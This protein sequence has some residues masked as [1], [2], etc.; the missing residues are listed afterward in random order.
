MKALASKLP[1][2][3]KS[4][5]SVA[6]PK[7]ALFVGSF[8]RV[9][10][11]L[12]SG[13][14]WDDLEFVVLEGPKGGLVSPSRD[15][16]FNPKR[17][18][19]MLLVG[20]EPGTYTL[21]VRH[22][23]SSA[24]LW[25]GKFEVD[26]LW[27]DL[28]TGP[29]LWFTGTPSNYSTG[30]A[31]GGGTAGPQNVNVLPATGTRRIAVLLA[32][33]TDQRYTT[34]APT[35][36]QFR[37]RW[38]DELIDGVVDGGVTRSVR[39][40]YRE[41]SY[42]N[43]DISAQVFG[44]VQLPGAW[45]DYFAMDSGGNWA[46]AAA[47]WQA[48]V[49]AG[50][51]LIDYTQFDTLVCVSQ[52][53]DGPPQ[54]RA[55]PYANGGTF[56]TAEGNRS[57]GVISMPNEW[58]VVG[59]REIFDTFSHELGHN[60]GLGD[61]YTPAVAGR[62]LG[63]WEMMD[64]DDP[65]PHFTL[66]H[67]MMLGWVQSGWVQSFDFSAL[68]GT[69]DQTVTLHPI[70]LGNPASGRRSGIEIRI[71]DGW[72]YYL[73]YRRGQAAHIG[74]RALPED[75]IVLGTDVVSAPYTP[76]FSR[77]GLL[78]LPP[79]TDSEGAALSN[80]ENYR[81]TDFSDPTYP[82]DFRVDVSGIDA[83]KADVR[84]RYGVLSKP[85][86]SIRPW[87]AAPDRQWQSPDIE[88]R[89][90]RNQA[91]A[92]WFNVPWVGNANTIVARV[93]NNGN[94]A[95]PQVRVNFYVKNYNVG[96]APESFLGTDARDIPAGAAVEFSTGWVP[97]SNGHYCVIVRIPLYQTPATPPAVSVVEM[98]ELNN[99]AQSNYDR[100]IS[101]TSIPTREMTTVEVGNPYPIATRV[102]LHAGQTNPLYR[103]YLETTSVWLDPGEVRKVTVMFEYAPD[104]LINGVYPK[105]LLPKVREMQRVPNN[106]G[107]VAR[108]EDP[109]DNPR[110]KVDVLG[111]AQAQIVTGKS[112]HF[113]D[114]DASQGQ[115]R[116]KVVTV[117]D[118]EPTPGR[119]IVRE[120][121]RGEK[122]IQY[123]YRT[124]KLR[125]GG[126]TTRIS[127]QSFAVDA[128]YLAPTGYADCWSVTRQLGHKVGER[129][130]R[131]RA[132]GAPR[133]K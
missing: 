129:R 106:F 52:Q 88:V 110:H 69:V 48:C 76:P 53:V 92:A 2:A 31:W 75:G 41:V 87:P 34:D 104:N 67:R 102:F 83:N 38:M 109:N 79:D 17:P 42:N 97:P 21:Q 11:K 23:P 40:F 61:Q 55:W 45:T 111:G 100:F 127:A 49:T 47:Y 7:G 14:L 6:L 54:R 20:Y 44:P 70:E 13:I 98:T 60:L 46:P 71:A 128:Y 118:K 82:T 86:P 27:R 68:G 15:R 103:T 72:N 22:R 132:K 99:L 63:S 57:L 124:V 51:S 25:S 50:D 16:M 62:N 65:M 43:F 24:V 133:R 101:T 9:P 94:M 121:V 130:A 80:G 95:A 114:F 73:E 33:T 116:G 66:A 113:D 8:H 64:W 18:H 107:I 105:D 84:I 89:N 26:A 4:K 78:L 91:D 30:A 81:E 36:Q 90:V 28:K 77:P 96:G 3:K 56:T 5:I 85:D 74:D 59:N 19:F 122:C 37:D 35:L 39:Q 1:I 10:V 119:V 108:I 123:K 32:D 131:Q 120:H 29:S 117:E 112:T 125:N 12:G 115:V 126:F 58:G 93:K